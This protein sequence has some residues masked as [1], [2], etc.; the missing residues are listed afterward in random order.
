M[1]WWRE[2]DAGEHDDSLKIMCDMFE[3][4][5]G[6]Y[7]KHGCNQISG[8]PVKCGYPEPPVA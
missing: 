3:I 2:I 6:L 4:V 7:R 1:R 5:K 8:G